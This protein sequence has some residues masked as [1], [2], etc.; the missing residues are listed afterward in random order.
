MFTPIKSA[1][2][3]RVSTLISVCTWITL[4]SRKVTPAVLRELSEDEYFPE[5]V[6]FDAAFI[7]QPL[8]GKA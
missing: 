8:E 5:A 4:G 2:V 6:A 1:H 7:P 3:D